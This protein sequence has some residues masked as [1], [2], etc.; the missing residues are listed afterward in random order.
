MT[1][2]DEPVERTKAMRNPRRTRTLHKLRLI[3][4]NARSAA[5]RQLIAE[6]VAQLDP[7][8]EN[9]ALSWIEAVSEFDADA[10]K[11]Q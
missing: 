3:V 8:D 5:V 6:Q 1:S 2:M 11:E 10:A 4:P 9:E 7:E